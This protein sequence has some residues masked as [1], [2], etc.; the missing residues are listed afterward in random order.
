M[1]RYLIAAITLCLYI[2]LIPATPA[3]AEDGTDQPLRVKVFGIGESRSR[4]YRI[5]AICTTNSGTLI[6]VADK[7]G[8]SINDLPNTIS[9][10]A[11][12]STDGGATWS[13]AITLARGDKA[14][15]KTYGDPAIVC[16]R[17]TGALICVFV[18]D[19]G[20]FENPTSATDRQNIYYVKSVDDGMTW[21]EP[22]SISDQIHQD[23]WYGAF[24][25]SGAGF[26]DSQGRIM[27]VANCRTTPAA[28]TAGV[29]EYLVHTDDLGKT[30]H[31]ANPDGKDPQG[32]FGNESKVI[33]LADGELLMSM[34][35]G[36]QRRFMKSGDR[37][38]TWSE[39]YEA[40]QLI[41][42][43]D[44]MGC[45]GDIIRYPMANGKSV[46]LHSITACQAARRDVS[47]SVSYD[48]GKTWP[49]TRRIVDGPSAYSSLTVLPDGSIGCFVEDG[50][51]A[52]ARSAGGY[53]LYFVRFPLHWLTDGDK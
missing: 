15:G 3:V 13:E 48:E 35:Y 44:G 47:V 4:Y 11:K 23:G 29:Y 1:N 19:K 36:H 18:G 41:E 34:R 2:S 52:E 21:S 45:N 46:L 43:I 22:M 14:T 8:A 51:G 17:N 49:V 31:V 28:D 5:P 20:F 16:D 37:G 33:E 7:R 26:Q 38:A 53:D 10:V 40:T 42:P 39:P 30:W 50:T 6:A 9:V 24:C 12:R 27:F 32:G 25:A